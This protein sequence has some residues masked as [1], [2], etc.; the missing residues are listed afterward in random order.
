MLEH[1][2]SKVYP[3]LDLSLHSLR[4]DE[5]FNR[6]VSETLR[7][8]VISST[9]CGFLCCCSYLEDNVEGVARGPR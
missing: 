7:C 1:I 2:S 9:V 8:Y 6:P 3:E 5:D 4:L